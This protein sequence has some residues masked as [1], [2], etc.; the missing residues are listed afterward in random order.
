MQD[1][2]VILQAD[3]AKRIRAAIPALVLIVFCG[4]IALWLSIPFGP[5]G[6]FAVAVFIVAGV[7]WFLTRTTNVAL[8]I[9]SDAVVVHNTLRTTRL[10]ID[11]VEGM[12]L[13]P[14]GELQV[15]QPQVRKA[16]RR[17]VAKERPPATW[18]VTG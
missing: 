7:A 17:S 2:A 14:D 16:L 9:A 11:E 10:P 5:F 12:A 3:A 15:L 1:E 4:A 13:T 6:M 18:Q 8:S